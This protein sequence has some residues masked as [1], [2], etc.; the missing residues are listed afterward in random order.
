MKKFN[1][2]V[3]VA[4]LIAVIV[5]LLGIGQAVAQ[6]HNIYDI[7]VGKK[8]LTHFEG[9][10]KEVE[11]FTF[12]ANVNKSYEIVVASEEPCTIKAGSLSITLKGNSEKSFIIEGNGELITIEVLIKKRGSVTIG[13]FLK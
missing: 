2:F 6:P 4:T 10:V 12:K 13:V 5:A 11:Q 9:K 1:S 3:I 7:S 8:Y